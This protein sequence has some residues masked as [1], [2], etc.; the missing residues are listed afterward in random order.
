MISDH[1]WERPVAVNES[2][3]ELNWES[4]DELNL[5]L[6]DAF[7]IAYDR[8]DTTITVLHPKTAKVVS[9]DEVER[10]MNSAV[11]TDGE[12]I[13]ILFDRGFDIGI[14]SFKIPDGKRGRLRER[15]IKHS[16]NPDGFELWSTSFFTE[17]KTECYYLAK[18]T[19]PMECVSI[20]EPARELEP[21]TDDPDSPY[22]ISAAVVVTAKGGKWGIL[23]YAPWKGIISTDKRNQIL[24]MADYISGEGLCARLDSSEQAVL[25][26]RKND[27]GKVVC[28]SVTNCTIGRSGKQRLIIKNPESDKFL[29]VSQYDGEKYLTF[30]K[31]GEEYHIDFPELSPWSVG[32]VFCE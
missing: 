18:D 4:F 17:G 31:I 15:L 20:Y 11:I 12:S 27:V 5:W 28:V 19:A 9:A 10:L 29:F 7:P 25:L 16:I 1:G 8:Q 6:R 22:G 32:T 14:K 23:G 2:F 13:R 24:N 21:L 26:P 30:K 3:R